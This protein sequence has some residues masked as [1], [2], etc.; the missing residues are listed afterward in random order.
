MSEFIDLS[1]FYIMRVILPRLL[2]ILILL[3]GLFY[4][5]F[6]LYADLSNV[7]FTP[8]W[9]LYCLLIGALLI[10]LGFEFVNGFHDSANAVATVIYTYS[11]K[12]NTAVIWSGLFNFL[13]VLFSTGAVAYG[14]IALL[15]VDLIM[16]MGSGASFAMI[17]ALLM[18][19]ILWNLGTWWLGLPA[20]SSHTLIGSIVGV[21]IAH[22]LMSHTSSSGVN[23]Y[24]LLNVGESLLLSPILGFVLAGG[25]LLLSK[26]FLRQ[27][28]LYQTPKGKTPPPWPIRLLLILTCTTVS[29]AHG[30]NDGQKGMGLIML[31]LIGTVP[32]AYA[33]NHQLT[34][35]ELRQ[36]STQA[37]MARQT[38]QQLIPANTSSTQ[39]VQPRSEIIEMIEKKQGN[40]MQLTALAQ[41]IDQVDHRLAKQNKLTDLS[42]QQISQIRNDLYLIATGLTLIQKDQLIHKYVLTPEQIL[43]LSTYQRSIDHTTQFIP[44]WVKVMVALALGMGTLVGWKRIVVTVGEK[45]GQTHL[46]YAQG[47]SAEVAAASMIMAADH[48]GLPVST[49]HVLSSGIAGTMAANKSGLQ[50]KT[51]QQLIMAWILTLP[52]CMLLAGVLFW[53]F[54]QLV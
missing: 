39:I 37:Q 54:S 43:S 33:L 44:N 51:I 5:G 45:I 36:F 47:A 3:A 14:I 52:I 31:I 2:F 26:K 8:S 10:A 23:W 46:S 49:T 29:F 35:T 34:H 48:L 6:C 13:G 28:A 30:S 19:A 32:M 50:K 9:G 42:A 12:P 27:A 22:Q 21:G 41:L 4:S 25:L 53:L 11:L 1:F 40:S 15:P 17:F 16:Q 24:Q 38:V 20:S 7:I 18:A